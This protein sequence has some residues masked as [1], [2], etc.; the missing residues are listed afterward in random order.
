MKSSRFVSKCI[1]LVGVI[2]LTVSFKSTLKTQSANLD[3]ETITLETPCPEDM[4]CSVKVIPDTR[5]SLQDNNADLQ[6]ITD[7][8]YNVIAITINRIVPETVADAQYREELY[9]EVPKQRSELH[10]EGQDLQKVNAI[11]G[12]FC[13]CPQPAV[14]YVKI[15]HGKLDIANGLVHFV[16]DNSEEAKFDR[17]LKEIKASYKIH[18]E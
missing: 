11:F 10:L 15:D 8:D 14:G 16:F 9:V 3:M 18:D 2:C 17:V 7:T 4:E 1:V 6:F 5:L 12:R 13:F